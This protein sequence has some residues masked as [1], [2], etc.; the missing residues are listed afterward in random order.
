MNED[1]NGDNPSHYHIVG[2]CESPGKVTFR[3]ASPG[4]VADLVRESAP[5]D[6]VALV[7]S[8]WP[9]KDAFRRMVD[10]YLRHEIPRSFL[11]GMRGVRGA[12]LSL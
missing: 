6:V 12:G 11:K 7:D 5:V 2:F 1:R 4:V 10:P 9:G 8:E 3:P